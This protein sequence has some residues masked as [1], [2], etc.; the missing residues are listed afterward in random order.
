MNKWDGKERRNDFANQDERDRLIRID[1]N[2]ENL[3][4][5]VECHVV[6]DAKAFEKSDNK[7]GWLQKITFMGLGIIAFIKYF[8]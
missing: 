1:T 8:H 6:A 5:S 3:I 2:L 7:I 4:K